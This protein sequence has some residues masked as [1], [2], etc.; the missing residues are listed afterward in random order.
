MQVVQATEAESR[1][2]DVIRSVRDTLRR[3]WKM[4]ALVAGVIFALGVVV[5]LNLQA[6]YQGVTRIQIDPSRNPL[7][8]SGS[9]AQQQLASEAIETEVAVINSL[10]TSRTVTRRLNLIN[11]PEFGGGPQP[12]G[13]TSIIMGRDNAYLE[14]F[15]NR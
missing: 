1:L 13:S 14:K 12:E 6:S 4:L 10:D 9:E 8:R 15:N 5:T 7:A 3:R 2:G 11:D